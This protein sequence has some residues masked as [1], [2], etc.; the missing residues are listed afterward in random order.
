MKISFRRLL[1]QIHTTSATL[2]NSF[3]R[4]SLVVGSVQGGIGMLLAARMGYL[5]VFENE[6][7]KLEAESNRVNLSLIPPRRGWILDRHG[8]PL[9]SNHADFRVDAIPARMKNVEQEIAAVEQLLQLDAVQRQDLEDKIDKARGFAAV[10][11]ASGLEW[12]RFAAVSVR[13]PDLPGIVTQ[14][15]FSR[16]YPNGPSVA[17]LIGYVGPASAEEYQKDHDPLLITPGY[18]VGKD[19]LEKVF[20]KELR[21]KPGARR[22][23]VTASGRIVR[24]LETRED[25]PGQSIKLTIDGGLQDYAARRIGL[26]SA[27]VVVI[28]CQTGGILALCSMPAF[29]PNS[30]ADGIG[31]LEWKMLNEDDHIPLLNKALRGLYPP[32]STMKPMAALA[33]QLHGVSPDERVNCPGGYRLGRRFFRCDAVHGSVDMRSAIERS[34]NTYFWSMVHRVGYDTIA[35][36][37]RL[38][39]LG[40]EFDIPVAQQRY[41]TIPDAAWKMRRYHQEWTAADSLNASI[42]QGYVSV[43]PFQMAVMTSRIASGHNL[44]PSLLYGQPKPFGPALPFTPEQLAVVH[45]GM[46]NVV[47][48]SGTGRGSRIDI[49]GVLMAGKTGTAQVRRMISRGHVADW[50]SRDHSHFICYAPTDSPRYA[51][52]VVV[53]HGGFGAS[54]AA[55]IA[56]D[57]MTYLF[58]PGK[59]WDTL[60]AMEKGWG[61]TAQERLDAR[62]RQYVA[63]YGVGAPKVSAEEE[64]EKARKAQD[65]EPASNATQAPAE[66]GS[67]QEAV[68]GEAAGAPGGADAGGE[69]S[70]ANGQAASAT[71]GGNP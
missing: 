11:V 4:R 18:K 68:G 63:Q 2:R 10:E 31:R 23:E 15:G 47:N 65:A 48:G 32:G 17:H 38:L 6:K 61:G 54:A 40:Q 1:P 35:P 9:A 14:R 13:L 69:A 34:C 30:F 67:R 57:V 45:D 50:K 24:E 52:S 51:M 29:D 39:G 59:A 7:Y 25:T 22:V 64:I 41:G 33:F 60:L 53:E 20:E 62:Y 28:D 70:T 44:Q 8:T 12:E 19:G 66:P 46:F 27:A 16:Y 3:D 37:A 5:A 71:S 36:V 21:G 49:N 58:D 26:Q 56:K 43:S 42:G 55:P